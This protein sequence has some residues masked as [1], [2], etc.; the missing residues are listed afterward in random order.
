MLVLLL[1]FFFSL[2]FWLQML[3][4]LRN[5]G[6]RSAERALENARRRALEKWDVKDDRRLV[7]EQVE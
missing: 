1:F 7:V 4:R 6:A 5:T 3:A 2:F